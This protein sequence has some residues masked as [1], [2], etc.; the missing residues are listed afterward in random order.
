MLSGNW[1]YF[2]KAEA[3]FYLQASPLKR[4][5]YLDYARK[6]LEIARD[7]DLIPKGTQTF[8]RHTP[9]RSQ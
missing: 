1:L 8:N 2:A 5:F 6:K 4:K 9:F 7:I 3:E